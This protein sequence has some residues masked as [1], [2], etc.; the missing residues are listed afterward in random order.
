[1]KRVGFGGPFEAED[2]DFIL[3]PICPVGKLLQQCFGT[4][5]AKSRVGGFAK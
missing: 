5:K 4:E 3:M 1:M 2:Y